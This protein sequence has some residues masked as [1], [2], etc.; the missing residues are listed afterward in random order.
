MGSLLSLFT[1]FVKIGGFTIGGGYAMIP[2][3]ER[4]VIE[5]RKW[6]TSEGFLDVLSLAQSLPG[7]WAVNISVF[8]GYKVKGVKGAV[9]AAL[10]TILPSF[11]IILAI[12]ISFAHIED[13]MW[14]KRFFMGVRPAVIAL[15]AVPMVNAIKKIGFT[16]YNVT[17][18]ILT[19]ILIWSFGVSPIIIILVMG[20]GSIALYWYRQRKLKQ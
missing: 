18:A 5:R 11:I 8:V 4:E 2:L 15:I 16:P 9:A 17:I 13:N 20:I 1:T 12:A 10:G 3:V 19:A 7:I 6:I 14:V